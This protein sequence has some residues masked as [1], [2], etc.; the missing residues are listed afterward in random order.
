MEARE[1]LR[2]RGREE[3]P[4][5]D[6]FLLPDRRSRLRN[7]QEIE[8]A[9]RRS[10]Q[11]GRHPQIRRASPGRPDQVLL[12]HNRNSSPIRRHC[13]RRHFRRHLPAL[14]HAAGAREVRRH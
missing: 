5:P 10:L 8:G 12:R 9:R 14:R 1:D 7:R 4:I 13:L 6:P 2:R 11:E 3:I